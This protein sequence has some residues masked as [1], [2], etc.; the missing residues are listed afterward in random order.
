MKLMLKSTFD[1][2]PHAERK[3]FVTLTREE[4]LALRHQD[5]V[6]LAE[7]GKVRFARV[8]GKLLRNA[9]DPDDVQVRL[10]L[11]IYSTCTLPLAEA[12]QRLVRAVPAASG[13]IEPAAAP[14]GLRTLVLHHGRQR[15]GR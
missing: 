4:I 14:G 9:A 2:R 3:E 10:K 12:L 6:I 15:T 13:H 5:K 8:C 7:A 1:D 11:N